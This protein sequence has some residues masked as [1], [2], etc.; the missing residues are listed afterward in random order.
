VITFV[1]VGFYA[2][3]FYGAITS[4]HKYNRSKT[5]QFIDKLKQTQEST[6]RAAII[7]RA[8]FFPFN[9]LFRSCLKKL[10]KKGNN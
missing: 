2:G 8:L 1:E 6:L 9:I 3:N 5:G 7:K 10:I 4:A